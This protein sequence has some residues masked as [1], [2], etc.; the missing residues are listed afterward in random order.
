[1]QPTLSWVLVAAMLSLQTMVSGCVTL[2]P[3]AKQI[4]MVENTQEI[5]ACTRLG[6]ISAKSMA[7]VDP[8]SCMSAAAAQARNQAAGKGATHLLKTY[9]GVS[10]THGLF[11]GVAFRCADDQ[12]GVQR[13]EQKV[14]NPQF[15][16]CTKDIE[17]R[18]DRICEGGKCVYPGNVPHRQ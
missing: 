8:A 5:S 14:S 1:M 10:L 7:C 6:H 12:V 16:G 15:T 2:S 3:Q 18:G 17:C 4:Y 9:T 11:E 13:I